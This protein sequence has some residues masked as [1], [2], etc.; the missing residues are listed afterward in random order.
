MGD[1]SVS[2][3]EIIEEECVELVKKRISTP[4]LYA[5]QYLKDRGK[6]GVYNER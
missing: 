3:G 1:I 4:K 5:H 6:N 2:Q